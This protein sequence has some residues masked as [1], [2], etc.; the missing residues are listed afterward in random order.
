MA[1]G[2]MVQFSLSALEL[3]SRLLAG[4]KILLLA[5][6]K[7]GKIVTNASKRNLNLRYPRET[8]EL[9]AQNCPE[10]SQLA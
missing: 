7:R 5:T 3:L 1:L 10:L 6:P 2:T 8:G 9:A 4:S